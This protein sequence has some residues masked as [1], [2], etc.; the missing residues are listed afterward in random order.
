MWKSSSSTGD[1][2]EASTGDDLVSE[3]GAQDNSEA[4][5]ESSGDEHEILRPYAFEGVWVQARISGNTLTWNEGEDVRICALSQT[6]FLMYYVGNVYH[7]ELCKDGRLHWDDNDV[8]TRNVEEVQISPV[9][10]QNLSQSLHPSYPTHN[11]SV[12]F[13]SFPEVRTFSVPSESE[14]E[15]EALVASSG[16]ERQIASPRAF[17]GVWAQA[18]ISGST[19]TWNE[20]EDVP[21]CPL[22]QTAFRMHYVDNVYY[23]ELCRDGRLHW[24]DN[25]VWTRK[26]EEVKIPSAY[27]Q[28]QA[29][30]AADVLP[31]WLARRHR[32]RHS[33]QKVAAS[34]TEPRK[35]VE[36]FSREEASLEVSTAA[37]QVAS[38]EVAAV[39]KIRG[40][41]VALEDKEHAAT[42]GSSMEAREVDGVLPAD[43]TQG[44]SKAP[45]VL[46]PVNKKVYQGD[47]KYFRGSYGWIV[48][49]AVGVDYPGQDIMVHKNDCNF[50][51][52]PWRP[53]LKPG[54]QVR[55][56]LALNNQGNPQ[57][58]NVSKASTEMINAKDWFNAS[59][60]TRSKLLS[61]K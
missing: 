1:V 43:L 8:W 35:E 38:K 29:K 57:A 2:S 42:K 10:S 12:T 23:A 39:A 25:D 45:I 51:P 15:T 3:A 58:V 6:A 5:G 26:V 24:D 36:P 52:E 33:G 47:V 20:G 49:Q 4:A 19:L 40:A 22:S 13:S 55:F 34:E 9:C 60:A 54:D 41:D 30:S 50:K 16:D 21:I 11:K 44:T 37:R 32:P 7:A 48:C 18:R 56:R 46:A 28:T 61:T 31:P 59:K 27:S 53:L 14:I 17:E